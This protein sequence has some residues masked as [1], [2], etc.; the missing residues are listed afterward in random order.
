MLNFSDYF[1]FFNNFSLNYFILSFILLVFG[2]VSLFL[3]KDNFIKILLSFELIVLANIL[4]FTM[5]AAIHN[6]I[7]SQVFVIMIL[8]IAAAES[9][10]GLAIFFS[11][12]RKKKTVAVKDANLMRG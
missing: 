3:N 8:T 7:V 4:N 9:A 12:F 11:Y 6:D 5:C 10:I 1:N 2:L